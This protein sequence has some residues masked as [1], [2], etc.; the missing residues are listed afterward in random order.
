MELTNIPPPPPE[1][2]EKAQP[3][4]HDY[5]QHRYQQLRGLVIHFRKEWPAV[6]LRQ[7]FK[8]PLLPPFHTTKAPGGTCRWCKLPTGREHLKW[9]PNCVHAYRAAAAQSLRYLWAQGKR[10]DCPCGQPGQELDHKDALI[11]AWTSG[12]PRRLVRAYSLDNILWL[13]RP[14]HREKTTNDLRLLSEMR[15]TQICLIGLIPA[16]QDPSMGVNHWVLG[17]VDIQPQGGMPTRPSSR[18]EHYVEGWTANDDP[19][20]LH[21]PRA[22]QGGD[23][24]V[25]AVRLFTARRTA[26][27][28]FAAGEKVRPRSNPPAQDGLRAVSHPQTSA[29]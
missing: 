19:G 2:D 18:S 16:P 23:P 20:V 6:R 26:D 14:C 24:A 21:Q 10:P 13:C 28:A 3:P 1:S 15:A 25:N 4:H 8:R 11:L 17:T 22:L 12:D 9:H 7:N 27:P 29:R 5:N